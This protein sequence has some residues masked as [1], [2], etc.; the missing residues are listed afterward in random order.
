M[1]GAQFYNQ[2]LEFAGKARGHLAVIMAVISVS[3][4]DILTGTVLAQ[5]T[6]PPTDLPIHAPNINWAALPATLID[7]LTTP[8]VVG[9]GVAL[10]IWV[11]LKAMAFFK[12]AA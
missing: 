2:F 5:T 7:V 3:M 12:R 1:Y 4:T 6:T 11:I 10:S 9:I 8:V